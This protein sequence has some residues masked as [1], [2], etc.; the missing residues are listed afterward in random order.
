MN[1]FIQTKDTDMLAKAYTV[2]D[3]MRSESFYDTEMNGDIAAFLG[4]IASQINLYRIAMI[5]AA[6][7]KKRD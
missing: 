2:I 3:D 5:N 7:N 6:S 1:Q 4:N